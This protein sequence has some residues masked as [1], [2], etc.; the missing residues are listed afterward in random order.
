MASGRTLAIGGQVSGAGGFTNAGPGTTIFSPPRA[1]NYTYAGPTVVAAGTLKVQ[2]IP[3]VL[4]PLP[5]AVL[6][7]D[8]ADPTTLFTD[9]AGTVPVTTSGDVVARWNDKSG[10]GNNVTLTGTQTGPTYQADVQLGQSVARFST[11]TTC[12][13]TTPVTVSSG[14]VSIFLVYSY[15]S[16]ASIFRR[17]IQ[18]SN[19][20]LMGPYNHQYQTYANGWVPSGVSTVQDQFVLHEVIEATG[21]ALSQ[22][23]NGV[24]AGS[25]SGRT[26]PG[27]LYLGTGTGG[28]APPYAEPLDGDIAELLVYPSVLSAADRA[29]VETYLRAKWQGAPGP[30]PLPPTTPVSLTS[31]SAVLNLTNLNGG[32][33][34][35]LSG[36]SGS[37]VLLGGAMLVAGD[38]TTN[39][40]AGVIS[41]TGSLT[42]AG[43]GVL[44]LTG[45]NTYT[46]GTAIGSG[47]ALQLG[48][49]TVKNGEVAG[50]I[51]DNGALIIANPA[52]QAFPGN[53]G[54]SG[55]LTKSGAGT[56]TLSGTVNYAGPTTVNQGSLIYDINN[57]LLSVG[58]SIASGATVEFNNI[59]A[60]QMLARLGG[61]ISGGGTLRKNSSTVAYLSWDAGVTVAMASGSLIDIRQGTLLLAYGGYV[62]SATN[63]ADM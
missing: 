28:T 59:G 35:S 26:Y 46:G 41:G 34:G 21:G 2:G 47:S 3:P 43:T 44:T 6:W 38:A 62:K 23:I 11:D 24:P 58:L 60:N 50:N 42:E 55:T 53:I 16:D 10:H 14:N 20:W 57:D 63:K 4:S 7:L 12:G 22:Y 32:T 61:T 19:N 56:L 49:G 17:A 8:G 9:A 15:R 30:S 13:M 45:T 48:D 52:D 18:G 39:T 29:S 36:V 40:F 1:G 33:I 27:K 54:G 31:A 51:T 5:G 37:Q 25:S